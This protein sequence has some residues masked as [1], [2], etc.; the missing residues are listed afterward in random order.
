MKLATTSI[1]LLAALGATAAVGCGSSSTT[2]NVGSARATLH[3]SKN[4]GDLIGGLRADAKAKINRSIDRQIQAIQKCIANY[5]ESRCTGGYY[6]GGDE[7]AV[8]EAATGAPAPSAGNGSSSSGGTGGSAPPAAP[9][10]KAE[11]YSETN[12]QVKGVDEADIVKTDGSSLFVLHGKA[13]KIVKAWPADQ[14][15]EG[16]S[17]DIEGTPSEMFV[18]DGKAVVYSTVNGAGVFQA[19]GI[20]PKPAYR[21]YSWGWEGGEGDV[22]VA[23]SVPYYPGGG[24]SAPYVP[25]TKITVLELGA[26]APVVAREVYFEGRYLDSR[27][28]G[29]HVRTVLSGNAHGPKLKYSIYDLYAKASGSPPPPPTTTGGSSGAGGAEPVQQPE[30]QYPKTGSEMIAALNQ[31]RAQ[32][33]ATIDASQLSDW[34]PTTFTKN[35]TNISAQT[36][37][38]EDFYFPTAGTTASGLT[39]VAS[40]DLAT[41]NALPRESA[42]LGRADTV[43]GSADTLYLAARAYVEPPMTAIGGDGDVGVGVG[44]PPSVGVAEPSPAPPPSS[45]GST[46]GNVGTRALPADPG[47]ITAWP[48]NRTHIHKFEFATDARFPNYVASGTVLGQVKDQFSMD[49]RDGMMRISTTENRRYVDQNGRWVSPSRA[50]QPQDRPGSV[51]HVFV[52]GAQGDELKKVG[53]VGELAPGERIYS[54]R[55]VGTRAYVVTFRQVDPLFVIDLSTP[56]KPLLKAALKIPGFSEYMHPLDDTHLLTIGRDATATGQQRG[57]QLQIFDVTDATNPQRTHLFTYASTQYGQSEAEQDHK[58]FTYFADKQMLAFPFVGY[59]NNGAGG[60]RSS[61][62]LFKVDVGAGFTQVGSIDHTSLFTQ[63]PQG[64][65]GGYYGPQVRRGVFME[66]FVYSISYGGIV[67]RKTTDLAAPGSQ[68]ALTAPQVNPGYGPTC[69]G[70]VPADGF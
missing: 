53:D 17:I 9:A 43:Y 35:G 15:A 13:F 26:G 42:I 70:P 57:L 14:L 31:L 16:T 34:L 4:C 64:Y 49:D 20:E 25:L 37:A 68:L 54:T 36:V 45:G 65:C 59:N 23:E 32:N 47:V 2:E 44:E 10:P 24:G 52:L 6:Y 48:T 63:N 5:G 29:T 3:R 69:G 58:A 56:T 62:E 51:N 30:T 46:S 55:F 28:V 33:L 40:I 66:D 50:G 38:C 22:A 12:T 60:M 18:A 27:R 39:E 67:V 61:L 1:A 7:R 11:S 8:D 19:A 41:P 21:D